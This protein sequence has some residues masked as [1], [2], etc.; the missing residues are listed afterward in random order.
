MDLEPPFFVKIVFFGPILDLK[1][2]HVMSCFA[3]QANEG[4]HAPAKFKQW[5]SVHGT[6]TRVRSVRPH[7]PMK[8]FYGP[9]SISRQVVG[10][11]QRILVMV[12]KN[13]RGKVLS[14]IIK[15]I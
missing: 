2:G 3:M 5:Q 13:K 10:P 11:L 1:Q 9:S 7:Y 6:V 12:L 15:E 14:T 4:A 8:F